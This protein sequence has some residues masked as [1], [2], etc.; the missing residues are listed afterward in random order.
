M[1]T[2]IHENYN[3]RDLDRSLAF[4]REAL[5][6][7]EVRRNEKPWRHGLCALVLSGFARLWRVLRGAELSQPLR[8]RFL[9]RMAAA[10]AGVGVLALMAVWTMFSYCWDHTALS[11]M[12]SAL[13]ALLTVLLLLLPQQGGVAHHRGEGRF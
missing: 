2:M 7:H 4:Y 6:L 9:G 12:G 13:I 3:V 1:F 10:V 8:R 5:G 11:W